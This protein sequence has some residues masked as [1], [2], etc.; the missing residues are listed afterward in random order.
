MPM[1]G[2]LWELYVQDTYNPTDQEG[3]HEDLKTKGFIILKAHHSLCDGVSI[4]CMILSAGS[5]YSRDYFIKSS[6][7]K[8]WEILFVNLICIL[9][10]PRVLLGTVFARKDH[11]Y[12]TD[13]KRTK[14]LAG[15]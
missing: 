13:A 12:I 6:D 2:P 5:E 14:S 3:M 11:N 10:L 8:W 1:D 4:M 15:E 9:Q 7:P